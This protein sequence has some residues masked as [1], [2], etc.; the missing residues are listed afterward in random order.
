MKKWEIIEKWESVKNAQTCYS[1]G[2]ERDKKILEAL[3]EI[4]DAIEELEDADESDSDLNEVFDE[5]YD[6]YAELSHIIN[7]TA[8]YVEVGYYSQPDEDGGSDA[9]IVAKFGDLETANR[10]VDEIYNLLT[11]TEQKKFP[12]LV[13]DEYENGELK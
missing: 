2:N 3:E 1:L 4:Q 10:C 7:A 11:E 8:D 5:A 9:G 13:I 12:V 6:K